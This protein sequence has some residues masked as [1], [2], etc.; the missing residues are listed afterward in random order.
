V[1]VGLGGV[2]HIN[3]N[4]SDLIRS[5]PFYR[6]ELGLDPVTRSAPDGPQAGSAFGLTTA[7]WDAYMMAGPERFARPVVDL[8]EWVEPAPVLRD[9]DSNCGFQSLRFGSPAG[10]AAG[11]AGVGAGAGVGGSL[12]D[13][14][15]VDIE[16]VDG[17]PGLAGVTIGCSD[18]A[19]SRRFYSDIVDLGSFVELRRGAGRAPAAANTV[20]PW[21]MALGTADVDADVE[22][23]RRAGVPCLSDPVDMAM[24]PGL[25]VL[26]FVLFSDPDGTM[27]ELIERPAA[28]PA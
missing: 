28:I 27:L 14:D 6:D 10:S 4:C 24:G 5:M 1:P 19:R 21:R 17:P 2:I 9:A 8:L 22:W 13:P 23:L 12:A 3:V 26:R 25:P 20:G 16:L 11:V 7:H 18:L 15:G